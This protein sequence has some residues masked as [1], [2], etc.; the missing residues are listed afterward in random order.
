ML[1]CGRA[2]VRHC[3]EI[4]DSGTDYFAFTPKKYFRH[5]YYAAI[6]MYSLQTKQKDLKVY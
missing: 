5:M 1:K 4:G 3:Q 2:P 6:N